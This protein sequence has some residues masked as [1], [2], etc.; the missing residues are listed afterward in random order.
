MIINLT[1]HEVNILAP[2]G[3]ILINPSR[4]YDPIR[5]VQPTLYRMCRAVN[6]VEIPIKVILPGYP[7]NNNMPPK[8]PGVLYIVSRLVAD[9][10]KDTRH[11]FV[12]PYDLQR[13]NTG[14]IQGCYSL[15]RF[16][17]KEDV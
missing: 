12:F 8:T 4:E 2:S 7:E 1:P 15:A 14:E 11:D 9:T 17:A 10:F 3:D 5:I 16:G 6:G 13:T